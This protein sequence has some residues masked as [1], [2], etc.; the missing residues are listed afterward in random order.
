[1]VA[2]QTWN[3]LE[4]KLRNRLARKAGPKVRA[5]IETWWSSR[6]TDQQEWAESVDPGLWRESIDFACALDQRGRAQLA[7]ASVRYGGGG[8]YA[9]LYFLVR[10][11]K[12][13]Y[14]LETGVAAGWSSTAILQ[15]MEVNGRGHLWSSDAPYRKQA[16]EKDS[17]GILV[18]PAL[19]RRWTLLTDGDVKNLPIIL[20]SLPTLDF[21][22]YDSDKRY[23]SRQFVWRLVSSKLKSGATVM[24]DDIQDNWHFRD[25][26]PDTAL[27]FEEPAQKIRKAVGMWEMP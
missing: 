13:A 25:T 11:R 5:Q 15:A 4:L 26:A 10:L 23:A 9:L 7:N 22:H 18:P 2:V 14:A 17:I 27:I 3:L 16:A 1:M 6:S 8:A 20:K 12:P 19:R 21:F 24:F